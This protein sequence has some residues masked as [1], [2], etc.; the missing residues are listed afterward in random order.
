[1]GAL[2][3][4]CRVHAL[5]RL[6]GVRPHTASARRRRVNSQPLQVLWN[7]CGYDSAGMVAAEVRSPRSAYPRALWGTLILTTLLYVLPL[8]AALATAGHW[9]TWYARVDLPPYLYPYTRPCLLR[10][11]LYTHLVPT[12]LTG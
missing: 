4:S 6:P 2:T 5:T 1:M 11:F 10:V 9:E 12:R 7:C 3:G 8:A